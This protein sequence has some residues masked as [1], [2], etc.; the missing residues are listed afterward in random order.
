M[1]A[2]RARRAAKRPRTSSDRLHVEQTLALK[3]DAL[4][5]VLG[6]FHARRDG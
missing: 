6:R 3:S 1:S 4:W 2:R 5:G